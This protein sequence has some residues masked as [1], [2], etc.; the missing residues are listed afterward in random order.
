VCGY[1]WLHKGVCTSLMITVLLQSEVEFVE[2]VLLRGKRS[3]QTINI[4]VLWIL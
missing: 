3:G 2:L 4:A 1:S